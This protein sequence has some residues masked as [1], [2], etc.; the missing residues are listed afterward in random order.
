MR[1]ESDLVTRYSNFLKLMIVLSK[2][3]VK[4]SNDQPR[5]V[6]THAQWVSFILLSLLLAPCTTVQYN[7][8]HESEAL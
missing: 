7:S 3:P 2:D 4:E 1:S 6:N 5:L 8:P